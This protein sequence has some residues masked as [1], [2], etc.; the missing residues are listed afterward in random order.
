MKKTVFAQETASAAMIADF[1][2]LEKQLMDLKAVLACI[3]WQQE[4]RTLH[5]PVSALI[6]MGKDV[7]LEISF[8]RQLDQYAFRA[9]IP[10][11]APIGEGAGLSAN[12]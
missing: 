10:D 1:N 5:V 3:A 2:K 8:D 11:A 12:N 6:E 9:S 4:D 7:Q